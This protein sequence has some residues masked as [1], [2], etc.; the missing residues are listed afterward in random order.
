MSGMCLPNFVV[1]G[2]PKSGTTSL[3]YYLKQHPDVWLPEKKELHYFSFPYLA[4]N[5]AGPGDQVVLSSLCANLESYQACYAG[6]EGVVRVG[7]FSPSYLYFSQCA[8]AI[9]EALGIVKIII[10]LRNPTDKAYSQ[11]MHLIRENRERLSFGEALKQER[12]RQ[13]S[14]WSDI[15][16]YAESSLYAERVQKYGEVFGRENLKVIVFEEFVRDTQRSVSEVCEFLGLSVMRELDTSKQYNR[17]GNPR[18]KIVSSFFS[19]D[20]TVK[21]LAKKAMPESIRIKLRNFLVDLNTGKKPGMEGDEKAYLDDYFA[22]DIEE[23]ERWL[24][25][26]LPWNK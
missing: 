11:Y 7:D 10:M 17:T 2:A 24:D 4:A 13:Q 12:A 15:W 1:V 26:S 20:S 14:G 18:S 22:Q 19:R 21:I 23:L 9:A 5:A 8:E 6:C 25:R 16:R 3:F